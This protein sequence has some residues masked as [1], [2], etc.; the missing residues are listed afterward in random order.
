MFRSEPRCVVVVDTHALPVR[1]LYFLV[2]IPQCNAQTFSAEAEDATWC[3]SCSGQEVLLIGPKCLKPANQMFLLVAME[4][5]VVCDGVN[6][7]VMQ[8]Q[9]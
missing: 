2:T 8:H 1:P 5:G 3:R 7:E 6:E 4:A 9:Q